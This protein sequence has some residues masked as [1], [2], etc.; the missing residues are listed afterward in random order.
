[1]PEENIRL[2]ASGRCVFLSKAGDGR[3]ETHRPG[4]KG[5]AGEERECELRR[6][7]K[8]TNTKHGEDHG[9]QQAAYERET[10]AEALGAKADGD[11]PQYAAQGHEAAD[12]AE[13]SLGVVK[14]EQ[15]KV[16][17]KKEDGEAKVEKQRCG[18]EKPELPAG[19]PGQ[20][21]AE[22]RQGRPAHLGSPESQANR[23]RHSIA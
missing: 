21:A 3:R 8:H 16:E 9:A 12:Q 20:Q 19:R 22:M 7:G 6:L 4:T 23:S 14:A 1:M 13:R 10:Q 17:E 2:N 15:V 18:E 11:R 5:H